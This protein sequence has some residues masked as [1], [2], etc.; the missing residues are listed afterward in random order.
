MSNTVAIVGRPNVGKSTFFNRLLG[1]RK[2]IVDEV[3]GVTRDR[4]YGKSEWNGIE[5]SLIDTGGYVFGSSDVFEK[6]IR[7]QVEIALEEADIILFLVDVMA[8]LTAQDERVASL[9]RTSIMKNSKE[10]K[11][12]LVA[13]KADTHEKENQSGEFYKLGMGDVHCISSMTGRGT[14]ELLDK[15]ISSFP[16][17]KADD[18]SHLPKYAIVGRPN[19][20]K[21]SLLNILLGEERAIV[22][23]VAGTTRDAIH[24]HYKKYNREFLLIDTA[25]IRKKRKFEDDVEFYSNLRA[26]RSIEECDVVLLMLDSQLGME[27]QD[28]NIFRL[29]ER[30]KKGVVIL[31]NKWDLIEKKTETA[32]AF[33]NYVKEKIAP[34]SDVPVLFISAL[35]KQRIMKVVETAEKVFQNRKKKILDEELNE[36]MLPVIEANQ[37]SS[38]KGKLVE[39]SHAVQIPANTPIFIFYCNFPKAIKESYSRFLENKLREKFD[40]CGVP[41]QIYFRKK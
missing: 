24:T 13:N 38:E 22:T 25:G 1:M 39:I 28:V 7:R 37:P 29:A 35:E 6:E 36:T 3:A 14:G 8:G 12:F 27:A 30:N 17:K 5:F 23:P 4:H 40:F 18:F 33:E 20:G 41:M 26:I 16:D 34:F 11:I 10:K 2:A 21:S 31:V 15:V 19:A 9:L 32:K